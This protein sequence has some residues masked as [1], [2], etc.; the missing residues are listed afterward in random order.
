MSEK[1]CAL[2]KRGGGGALTETTLWTNSSPTSNMADGTLL[3]LSQPYSDF[4]YI[5]V[6]Y[7]Y[8]VNEQISYTVIFT[9]ELFDS[10]FNGGA[11][12]GRPYLGIYTGA[13]QIVRIF[14]GATNNPNPSQLYTTGGRRVKSTSGD[15]NTHVIP[16]KIIGLK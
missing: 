12:G 9:K 11:Y 5:K 15:L 7:N 2:K 16:T 6:E 10:A 3:T 13:A 4:D 14:Y 8:S 1:L